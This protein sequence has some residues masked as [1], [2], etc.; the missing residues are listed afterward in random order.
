MGPGGQQV[1]CLLRVITQVKNKGVIGDHV[2][3]SFMSRRIQPLQ[4]RQ[5]PAFRYEG[6]EDA[7]RM[8]PEPMAQSDV[9]KRCYKVLDNFDKSLKLSILF[10]ANNPPENAWVSVEKT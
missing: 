4:H 5:L 3:F 10:W 7:T 8:S 2:V 6:I 9:I 1:E